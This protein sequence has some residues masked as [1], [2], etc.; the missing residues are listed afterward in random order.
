MTPRDTFYPKPETN[1]TA[2]TLPH[3]QDGVV[4]W[5]GECMVYGPYAMANAKHKWK[6]VPLLLKF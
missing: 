5:K 6:M 3:L 2:L 1:F 4:I